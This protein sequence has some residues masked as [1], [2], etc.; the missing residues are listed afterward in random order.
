MHDQKRNRTEFGD[1]QTPLHL[2]RE[3]C[4]LIARTGFR[5]ASILEPT[6]GIGS[7]LT[8]A[9]ETFSEAQRVLGFDINL[10][11]VTQAQRT[12]ARSFPHRSVEVRQS[13]FFL[14]NW[15]E[16]VETLPEPILVIG[17]P[18]WVT[19]AALSTLDSNNLPTKSNLDNL[20][21]IDAL[22]GKS[23]FDISEW[24]LRKSIEWLDDKNGLLAVLCKTTVARKV[25]L[26][27]CQHDLRID[28]ASVYILDA[29]EYFGAS[30]DSCL[31]FVR[32]NL[33]GGGSKECSVFRSLHAQKPDTVFGLQDGML[34]ADV[35]LYRKWKTL[36]G[37]GLRGWRSGIKHDCSKVFELRV[38]QGILVNGL[39]EVVDL[40]P[41]VL[42]PLLK[43]SDLAANRSPHLWMIVPQQTMHDDPRRLTLDA[44]RAWNYLNEHAHLLERRKSSVYRN[45]PPFSIFGVGPY[46]FAPWK[47]AISGLYKKLEF[48]QVSPFQDRPVVLDDTCYF[49]PC[50]SEEEC[51]LLYELVM[52]KPAREFWTS[53]IFWDAK[54]PITAQLLNSL[55]L[56]ALARLLGKE[57]EV[58]RTLAERQVVEY[59]EG[60]YQRLLFREEA[61]DYGSE[62]ITNN[63]D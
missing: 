62:P 33:T 38:K 22:T 39:R 34:V 30:V 44:P 8:A 18:P 4:S 32:S 19:N 47:V 40:E 2:A 63:L 51:N 15:F 53:L 21:G 42:Y 48:V 24:M 6:C 16:I 57:C 5:P 20:R 11:Y 55:D 37:T 23:N 27:A 10:H 31:L 56:M 45:R 3:V 36:I 58:A 52:S 35:E 14:M 49:F 13:D 1:F 25:L 46:S 54:R 41:E 28:S 61:A 29:H 12:L 43:S 17:N 9:L 60:V 26:Y 50:R 59:S 7:F